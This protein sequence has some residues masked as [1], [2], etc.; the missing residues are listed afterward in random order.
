MPPAKVETVTAAPD[1]VAP[2]TMPY[3]WLLLP[4][5][6]E[7]VPLLL[8][9]PEKFEIAIDPREPNPTPP[10]RIPLLRAEMLPL[11][12]LPPAKE[13]ML[14]EPPD[15]AIPP[16]RIP[17][18]PLI[19][20]LLP[21]LMPPEKVEIFTEDPGKPRP[22]TRMPASRLN[23][24]NGAPTTAIVP[25][26]LMPLEKAA[27][28]TEPPKP[29]TPPTKMPAM[30]AEMVPRLAMPPVKVEMV[31]ATPEATPP[32]KIPAP[33]LAEM[34]PRLA[35]PPAKVEMVTQEQRP[36]TKM[37]EPVAEVIVPLLL[38]PPVKVGPLIAIPVAA[39]VIVPLL[40]M[41][42]VKVGPLI[43]IPV[44][45]LE[46]RLLASRLMPP[47]MVPEEVMKPVMVPLVKL[48]P[49]GAI[50]PSLVM[51]P[52]KLVLVTATQGVVCPVGLSNAA[53]MVLLHAAAA[54]AEDAPTTS[55]IT[56]LD[57]R[58]LT[59]RRR[60]SIDATPDPPF[61]GGSFA[62]QPLAAHYGMS[63]PRPDRAN[64]R[65]SAGVAIRPH[66]RS[67]VAPSLSR[68]RAGTVPTTEPAT[69][70]AQRQGQAGRASRQQQGGAGQL[71]QERL[72]VAGGRSEQ[73][74]RI[75]DRGAV[76]REGE[77]AVA[78]G[79]GER[80]ADGLRVAAAVH[81]RQHEMGEPLERD[82]LVAQVDGRGRAARGL[83]PHQGAGDR[84]GAG[85][86]DRRYRIEAC[87]REAIDDH[88]EQAF[89]H[90]RTALG[91]ARRGRQGRHQ[92]VHA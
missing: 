27:I 14:M 74:G 34:V 22:P 35:M 78:R 16:T 70:P 92:V 71:R 43:P 31:T 79:L 37:P 59:L 60:T 12:L 44:T 82:A 86:G 57:S 5:K 7:I 56:E 9:P 66:G 47:A 87:G 50:V 88:V 64:V 83:C 90:E 67:G 30:P 23:G 46:I 24:P 32:T 39:E 69:V 89:A 65:F 45:E 63:H 52:V 18:P 80:R 6:A 85:M 8:M 81:E 10:T 20:P 58:K 84:H 29:A 41:P 53:P 61:A 76:A 54:A 75:I 26:L 49:P 4:P 62:Y 13:A 2:T 40:L 33:P 36:P 19:V 55:A 72:E 38:M 48:M 3:F 42:P 11:L 17:L 21:L 77:A 73:V 25:V 28:V 51:L 1:P 15:V 91:I 68:P